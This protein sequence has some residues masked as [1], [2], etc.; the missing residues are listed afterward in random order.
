MPHSTSQ[1]SSSSDGE[2]FDLSDIFIGREQQIDLFNIY[3]DRWQQYMSSAAPDETLVTIAPSPSNK[4]Q[5]L[6]VLLYVFLL[7]QMGPTLRMKRDPALT[8]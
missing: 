7:I 5:G 4:L 2:A 3:L 8:K 1:G 6:I